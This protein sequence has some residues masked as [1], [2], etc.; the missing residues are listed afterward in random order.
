[1]K[2]EGKKLS[3][4]LSADDGVDKISEGTH[5]RFVI[6]AEKFNAGVEAKLK[7]GLSHA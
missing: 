4:S 6:N 2:V 1:E 3:F 7:K 5:E